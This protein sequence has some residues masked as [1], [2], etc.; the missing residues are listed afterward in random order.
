M[1]QRKP[2]NGRRMRQGRGMFHPPPRQPLP[3]EAI[4]HGYSVERG[5]RYFVVSPDTPQRS[6]LHSPCT[7]SGAIA[8]QLPAPRKGA[9]GGRGAAGRW[10]SIQRKPFNGRRMRQGRGMFHPLT[11]EPHPHGAISHRCTTG[12][13]HLHGLM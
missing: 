5:D 10:G 12:E 7:L 13:E 11:G 4:P 9:G 6:C 1:F 8:N 3:H 2:F